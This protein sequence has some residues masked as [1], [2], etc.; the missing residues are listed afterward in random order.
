M[1]LPVDARSVSHIIEQIHIYKKEDVFPQTVSSVPV[2]VERCK[3]PDLN[4]RE[5]DQHIRQKHASVYESVFYMCQERIIPADQIDKYQIIDQLDIFDFL[6]FFRILDCL[7][8]LHI[9]SVQ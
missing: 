4:D 9:L 5:R 1:C 8:V 7:I 2:N 3:I 6:F